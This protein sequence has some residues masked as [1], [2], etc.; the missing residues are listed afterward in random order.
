[1]TWAIEFRLLSPLRKIAQSHSIDFE[2][3]FTAF[4]FLRQTHLG[5]FG[6]KSLQA[7]RCCIISNSEAT[8][9]VAARVEKTYPG[10]YTLSVAVWVCMCGSEWM[11]QQR[12]S[13]QHRARHP[14]NFILFMNYKTSIV[15]KNLSPH[16]RS[17]SQPAWLHW[18]HRLLL[19]YIFIIGSLYVSVVQ[20]R[21]DD[22]TAPLS[23]PSLCI[24]LECRDGPIMGLM[25][26]NHF[27]LF[28]LFQVS[29][30]TLQLHRRLNESVGLR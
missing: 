11:K 3:L 21:A 26:F 8:A 19:H 20:Q 22:G 23:R 12:D 24:R 17:A 28:Y 30:Q 1:M 7:S 29:P 2:F 4:F 14:G 9:P 6:K 16:S 18:L 13:S 25:E 27:L 10:R 5:T 15:K